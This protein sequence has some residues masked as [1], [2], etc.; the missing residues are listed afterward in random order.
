[1]IQDLSDSSSAI[2]L[3]GGL[4]NRFG[5]NKSLAKI[6]EKPM[7]AYVV[8]AVKS[9]VDEVLVIT[10][11]EDN[12]RELSKVLDSSTKILLDE[13]KLRSP[14]V[15]ALTGFRHAEGKNSIL[16]ACDIPLVSAKVVSLLLELSENYDAVIPRWPNGYIEPLQAAYNT[17]KTFAASREAVDEKELRMRDVIS[18]LGN[19]LYLSTDD[20]TKLDPKLCTFLNVNTLQDLGQ[21]ESI[22]SGIVG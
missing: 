10:D 4:S 5:R 2:I 9:V 1:M 7:I 17:A 20:L 18:R 11:T 19:I 13:Y 14:V 6:L 22:L 12:R 3:S 8:D 21:I 15:G 16:L